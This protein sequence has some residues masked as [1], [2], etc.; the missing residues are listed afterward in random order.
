[1]ETTSNVCPKCGGT[2][3]SEAPQ[4]LCPHCVLAGAASPPETSAGSSGSVAPPPLETVAAA[5]PQLEIIELI[6]VG[7]MAV[8]YKARQPK[9]D[10]YAALK[11]LPQS[12]SADPTFVERFHREA[13]FLARLN[14][15]NIVAVYDFGQAGGFCFL[16]LEFVDGLNL[17]QAM[18]AG[19]FSPAEALAIVPTL[20]A[21][22]QYAHER[23][24]LHRDIKPENIL[25]DARGQ[26]KLAD[27][28]IAKLLQEP[29]ASRAEFTLTQGGAR[30]GTP[31]YMAPEQIEKPADVDHRADIYSLGVVFYELLTGELPLGRFAPPSE[32]AELDSRVDA[33]VFRALAKERELRQQ[34]AEEVKT[35]VENLAT[36]PK[37]KPANQDQREPA[38]TAARSR[39]LKLILGATAV[40]LLGPLVLVIAAI[41]S[42]TVQ[43]QLS[44]PPVSS[45]A[46]F[47]GSKPTT[48]NTNPSMTMIDAG[49]LPE[50]LPPNPSAAALKWH[51]AWQHLN[52]SRKRAEAGVVARIDVLAAER[53]LIVAESEFRG[54]PV[55]ASA[56]RVV[57]ARA[58]LD[59]TRRQFEVGHVSQSEVNQARLALAEAEEEL[60]RLRPAP[61][62]GPPQKQ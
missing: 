44:L 51:F 7:G 35:E 39:I 34:S 33:I 52:E 49:G 8:V 38:R 53:D 11:L 14:H 42:Y 46:P 43:R 21:A 45:E 25:L 57:Y 5:F 56:A 59:T 10:R 29:G 1:M 28:G 58:A 3:P 61:S 24:V 2:I 22:L 30:L 32:M 47:V 27:F 23:G 13:R 31:H 62:D 20:C 4:G 37:S 48:A 16:L 9:L 12:L 26:V 55:I 40:L 60:Q 17:R 50:T 15:P 54:Q 6:G 41:S 18:Q 19:R 36:P